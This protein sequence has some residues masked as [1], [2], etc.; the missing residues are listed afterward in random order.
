MT[1]WSV[2]QASLFIVLVWQIWFFHIRMGVEWGGKRKREQTKQRK[3][4]KGKKKPQKPFEGLTRKPVASSARRKQRG[5]SKKRSESHQQRLSESE[6]D[7][8]R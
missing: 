7:D 6:D 5:E 8:R 4:S 3:G 1:I 2:I